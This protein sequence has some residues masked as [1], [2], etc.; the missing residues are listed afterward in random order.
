[1]LVACEVDLTVVLA[2]QNAVLRALVR[3]EPERAA[4]FVV[5]VGSMTTELASHYQLAQ[6]RTRHEGMAHAKL[7]EMLRAH[8]AKLEKLNDEL[9]GARAQA[10][11][12]AFQKSVFLANMSHELRTPLNAIVA[13][14]SLMKG[15]DVPPQQAE[16]LAMILSSAEHL[17]ALINNILD[18]SKLESNS[19]E[20]EHVPVHLPTCL[21]VPIDLSGR[22]AL[23]KGLD[24]GLVI[25]ENVPHTVLGD[26]TRMRQIVVNLVS[27]AVKF[28]ERGSVVVEVSVTDHPQ[29]KRCRID[30]RD[31][32]V[33]IPADRLDAV[34]DSF[35]QSDAATTRMYGGTGLGLTISR[36]LA[37]LMGGTLTVDS[38]VGVGSTFTLDIP[39]FAT[40]RVAGPHRRFPEE[41]LRGRTMLYLDESELARRIVDENTRRWGMSCHWAR[42]VRSALAWIERGERFDVALVTDHLLGQ[43]GG[44]QLMYKLTTEANTSVIRIAN[45]V[46]DEHED[47]MSRV[48]P[49]ES[50]VRKPINASTLFDYVAAAVGIPELDEEADDTFEDKLVVPLRILVAEDFSVNQVVAE[51][52]LGRLGQPITKMVENGEEALAAAMSDP[53]DVILMDIQM[54]VLDGLAAT[55]RI[56][57]AYAGLPAR[58]RLIALTADALE[59]DRER[60]LRGG[61]DDYLS[62]PFT[63]ESLA[64]TLARCNRV[65]NLVVPPAKVAS[66]KTDTRS[67]HAP[68]H[69]GNRINRMQRDALK[70]GLQELRS[71][72]DRGH[73]GRARDCAVALHRVAVQVGVESQLPALRDFVEVDEEQLRFR[74]VLLAS[75]CRRQIDGL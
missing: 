18:L 43:L 71:E 32:G 4:E 56:L 22:A 24:L 53:Y 61:F 20:L 73:F 68:E 70:R 21:Q 7:N 28:T 6:M 58:P 59:G 30:V 65:A 62:K 60:M 45:L 74:G 1:M 47:K 29:Q 17:L 42:D 11:R 10:E 34:F 19:V 51:L 63:L 38:A 48:W 8:G 46:T 14:S 16:Q 9:D 31:Q 44:H 40:D 33:G 54:P 69:A 36:R 12:T 37:E 39:L 27:N 41:A 50:V 2:T 23:A 5:V 64:R 49:F 3:E 57:E 66:V 35:T 25:H 15:A 75:R 55:R 26:P 67:T 52:L 13:L 72:L